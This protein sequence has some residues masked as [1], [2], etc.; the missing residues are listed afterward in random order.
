[1]LF[2]YDLLSHIANDELEIQR[3]EFWWNEHKSTGLVLEMYG[4]VRPP[5]EATRLIHY[6][7]GERQAEATVCN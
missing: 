3:S 1:M 4:G 2:D 5:D 6:P 7:Y